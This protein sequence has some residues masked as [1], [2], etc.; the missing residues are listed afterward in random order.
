M[1][2]ELD[3]IE[4]EDGEANDHVRVTDQARVEKTARYRSLK[5]RR[6]V[7]LIKARMQRKEQSCALKQ[8]GKRGA[9]HEFS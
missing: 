3:H 9:D 4:E 6:H 2:N 8:R 1:A 5:V 7:A